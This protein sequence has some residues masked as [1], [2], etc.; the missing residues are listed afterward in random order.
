[1]LAIMNAQYDVAGVLLDK[2]AD[3]NVAD[4]VGMAPLYAAVD[5]HTQQWMFGRPAPK[6][7][8]KLTAV[9]VAK[10]LLAHG[11]NPNAQL[12]RPILQRHHD[13]GDPALGDGTTP[14]IRAA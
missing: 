3:P 8:G 7:T 12:T 14:F 13:A 6:L 1:M 10:G 11:A 4:Q 9:D 5:M 2:D